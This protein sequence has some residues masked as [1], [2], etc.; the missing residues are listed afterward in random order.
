MAVTGKGTREGKK[1]W[2][3]E[4]CFNK[5]FTKGTPKDPRVHGSSLIKNVENVSYKVFL[6]DM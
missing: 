5:E 6:A 1:K 3:Q 4:K 2:L